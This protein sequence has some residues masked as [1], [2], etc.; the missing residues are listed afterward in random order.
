[1]MEEQGWS[2]I[3]PVYLDLWLHSGE[4]LSVALSP[5]GA[6]QVDVVV[7]GLT[8]SGFLLAVDNDNNR[9]ELHPDGSHLDLDKGFVS[10][11]TS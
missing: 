6:R 4:K 10:R 5:D 8:E 11:K 3:E 9:H 1:M 2:A 7:R